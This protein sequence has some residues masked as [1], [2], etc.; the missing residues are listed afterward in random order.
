MS[1]AML[2]DNPTAGI[3]EAET[4]RTLDTGGENPGCNQGGLLILD[5]ARPVC[6]QDVVGALCASDYKFPQQQ[7]IEEGKAVVEHVPLEN[8]YTVRR[9]TPT[10]CLAL[11]NLPTDWCDGL[12]TP[13]PT[14][15]DIA[16]WSDVWETH[17]RIMGTSSRPKSR[18]QVVKWLSNP[19]SDSACYKLAGNGVVVRVAQW[20]LEGIL[21]VFPAM[22]S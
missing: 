19:F 14:E 6:Y 1:N 17:R 18:N 16:F 15:E 2:S 3:Y 10:E 8:S 13:E 4:A 11:M 9:L 7:Q 21:N 20:V 22:T 5:E 12:E